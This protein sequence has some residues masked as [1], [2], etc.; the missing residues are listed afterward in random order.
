MRRP[1]FASSICCIIAAAA[2]TA[3][4]SDTGPSGGGRLTDRLV[5]GADFTCALNH[6]GAAFCWG[7]GAAGQLGDG[8]RSES[9][10]PVR[11]DG[12]PYV[13]LTAT[14]QHACG[15]RADGRAECWGIAISH[16]CAQTQDTLAVPTAVA[17]S[18]RFSL[19]SIGEVSACGIDAAQH[20]FCWGDQSLGGLGSGVDADTAI[21][22]LAPVAGG[23]AFAIL[24]EGVFG[25]CGLDTGGQAWCWGANLFGELGI[26]GQVD[27]VA[28]AP[29]AVSGGLRFT[30]LAV[31]GAY[32]C[33]VTTTGLTECWG[34]N[35]AGALGDSTMIDHS[36]PAP[37][38]H[39][40]FV[41]AFAGGKND[42]LD[43]TCGLDASGAASCWGAND[44][45]QLGAASTETCHFAAG[46]ACSTAPVSVVGGLMFTTL[47][48]G[49]AHTCGLV[50]D[51][52]VYCWGRNDDGELG[53]GTTTTTSA[54]VL[55][56]FTP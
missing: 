43:H 51:G 1:S 23:H 21:P 27:T 56:M 6:A 20:A 26:G 48:L 49:D 40:N 34:V 13:R 28:V 50:A 37:V 47:A 12:G 14:G 33:G 24:S 3:C 42:I 31:G 18:T 29:L 53:N 39:A 15:L 11:V 41:A 36:V 16:C 45:G 35:V 17:T 9:A 4:S 54:P 32:A 5:A 46:E 30:Q 55:S 19:I 2:L 44:F 25:G 7:A 8:E 38:V 10:V 52:H 22:P